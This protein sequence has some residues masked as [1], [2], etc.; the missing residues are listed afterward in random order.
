MPR[1][2]FVLGLD[3]ANLATLEALPNAEDFRFHPLLTLKELKRGPDVPV[4]GLLDKAAAQLEAFDG[5][6]DAVVGYW[7]FPVTMMVPLLCERLGLP[8]PSLASVLRCEHKYWSRLLQADVIDEVPRFAVVDL[9]VEDPRPPDFGYPLWL[10]PVKSFASQFA[11]HVEDDAT[12]RAAVDRIGANIDRIGRPFQWAMDMVD[13][14]DEVRAAGGRA[15]LAEETI[16][17]RQATVEGFSRNGDVTIYGTVDSLLYPG[18]TSFLRYQY[19]STLPERVVARM[20]ELSRT[21]IPHIGLDSSTFNVEFFWDEATDTVTLLEVNPR[22][23]QSHAK[24]FADV[25]GAANHAY[26]LDLA[27]GTAPRVAHR[28]GRA[29][30]AAKWF[31]RRFTDGVVRRS[32]SAEDLG[33]C[34]REVPGVAIEVVAREGNR[35]SELFDQDSYSYQLAT[36]TVGAEHERELVAKYERCLELLPFVFTDDEQTPV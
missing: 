16:R 34:E 10:K 21:V 3:D 22:H 5:P 1:N 20:S 4:Q 24:L 7:D 11:Y 17:G 23:S 29:N 15:C 12:F 18:T 32:P 9:D 19:P 31:L 6:V 26:M 25:D 35:L 27:L 30:V 13:R 28:E 2:V 14:P 33:H 8:S 36:I